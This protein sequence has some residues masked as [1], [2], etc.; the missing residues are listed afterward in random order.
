MK[1]SKIIPLKTEQLID[2]KTIKK[3]S[4]GLD[5]F[6]C[7]PIETPSQNWFEHFVIEQQK[8]AKE[9]WR[10]ELF[11]FALV[12]IFI[13]SGIIFSLYRMPIIF[14]ILQGLGICSAILFSMVYSLKQVKNHEG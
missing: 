1:K 9:K 2:H 13:L 3:I 4:E 7:M 8:K 11:L 12:A 10:K 6:D 5:S 14:I